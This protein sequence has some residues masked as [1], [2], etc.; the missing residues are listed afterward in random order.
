MP[1]QIQAPFGTSV[2][3]FLAENVPSRI[4]R[5]IRLWRSE[6][7]AWNLVALSSFEDG[8]LGD[9]ACLDFTFLESVLG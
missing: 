6:F 5:R 4:S 2:E 1:C 8:L 3:Y 7:L 9:F